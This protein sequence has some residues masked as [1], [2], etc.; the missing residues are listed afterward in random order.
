[1]NEKWNL[2]QLT[3]SNLSRILE[4]ET[5]ITSDIPYQDL[6]ENDYVDEAVRAKEME[7]RSITFDEYTEKYFENLQSANLDLMCSKMKKMMKRNVSNA[8]I[9][10]SGLF[11]RNDQFSQR[12]NISELI[13]NHIFNLMQSMIDDYDNQY[14]EN[15]DDKIEYVLDE[16]V[17]SAVMLKQVSIGGVF[18]GA[19][20]H[21]HGPAFNALL[22]GQKEWIIFPPYKSFQTK[23]SAIEF[24]CYHHNMKQEKREKLTYYTFTQNVGD[25]VFIPREWSHAVLNVQPSIGIAVEMFI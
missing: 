5:F 23:Q 21:F 18:S 16:I 25:V 14:D 15:Q 17:Q 11:W 13:P 4:S 8:Y 12:F 20:P 22:M 7:Q 19:Q 24:F 10:D 3:L 2:S 9:F 1:M 6:Y